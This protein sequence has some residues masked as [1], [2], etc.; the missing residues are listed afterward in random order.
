MFNKITSVWRKVSDTF[1]KE[2]IQSREASDRM[3]MMQAKI[4]YRH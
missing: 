4:F 3:A 1:E 2:S